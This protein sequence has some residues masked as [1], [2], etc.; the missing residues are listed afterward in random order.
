M[1]ETVGVQRIERFGQR[2]SQSNRFVRVQS[3]VSTKI[4]LQGAWLIIDDVD[5]AAGQMIVR[6]FHAVIEIFVGPADV[7]N[8]DKPGVSA[9]DRFERGHSFELAQK[10]AFAFKRIAI[11]NFYRAQRAGDCSRQ[12]NLAISAAPDHA[13]Q[14][15][16]GNNWDL[17]GNLVGNGRDFT[18]A[19]STRQRVVAV[20]VSGDRTNSANQSCR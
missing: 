6:Q 10:R 3:F 8:V 15:V 13:Q 2:N 12:P 1:R 11:N 5:L 17:S 14:F 16:I 20:A 9:R 7:E 18:Q 4:A 19:V